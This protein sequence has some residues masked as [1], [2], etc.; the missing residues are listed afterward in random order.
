M[1]DLTTTTDRRTEILRAVRLYANGA[2]PDVVLAAFAACGVDVAR[3]SDHLRA[4]A[5]LATGMRLGVAPSERA[6][7]LLGIED[8]A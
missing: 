7:A 8:A 2:R 4:V 6:L 1:H 5:Q 3:N